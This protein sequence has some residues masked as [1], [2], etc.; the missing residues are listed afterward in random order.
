MKDVKINY[1]V[2]KSFE[3][4]YSNSSD[5]RWHYL[6]ASIESGV[7]SW[8]FTIPLDSNGSV[9]YPFT[10]TKLRNGGKVSAIQSP[11]GKHFWNFSEAAQNYTSIRNAVLE[12]GADI[13]VREIMAGLPVKEKY[14]WE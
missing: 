13:N 9:S 7:Y 1:P 5:G 6:E 4:K 14:D 8:R 11:A 3:S 12:I 10:V 2:E